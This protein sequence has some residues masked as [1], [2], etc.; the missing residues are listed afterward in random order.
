[1]EAQSTSKLVSRRPNFLFLLPDQ[2]R[3]DWLGVNPDLPLRT[4]NLDRLAANG[5]RF[6]R[7]FCNSPLCAPSRA[8]LAS[9]KGYE[10][11]GV[12]NNGQD[13]PLD[14]P[15]YYQ[16][17]R[18][19]GY[20]VA[21]VGKFDL[22]KAVLDWNL[23]GSRLLA[24]W[25][26]TEGIDNEGKLDGSNSFRRAGVPKGPYLAYL[27][28]RG[29]ADVYVQEH[30]GR[31][32]H[33][34]AYT[35]AMPDDGYCDNWVAENGLGLLRQFPKDQPWHL[36]VNFAGPHDPMDVT[37]AMR[38]RWQGV[39][40][41]LP[42]ANDHPDREGLLRNRQNYAAMIDNIDRHLGEFI[43]LV[44]ER[45]EIDNTIVVYS[46][47]HGEMLGDHNRWGKSVWYGP[48]VGVPLIIAGPGVRE[49][50]V[51]DALV[52]LQDLAAMFVDYASAEPMPG[53]DA[54][55][56]RSLLSGRA[57]VHRPYVI[58]GLNDW[59]MVFDGQHKLVTRPGE[60]PILFDLENDPLED[61][62]CAAEHPAIAAQLRA[63]LA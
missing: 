37:P 10:H 4:P 55:S 1:M 6:T 8:C 63:A 43:D 38:E 35:T 3:P 36:V 56:L 16:A 20:R 34:G 57:E 60:P 29:L 21:G 14:Q 7:A 53:M 44:R 50:V 39:D 2:H 33:L 49:G 30:E 27:H 54:R 15:T 62:N 32:Q 48:S 52:S 31:E 12:V 41:P 19:V 18:D 9:G 22:H 28:R 23:D 46:S 40:F 25:G 5:V 51:S 24:Q 17:L 13:Y 47:D 45:G 42:H 61:V 58:A 59:R 11:C 26:F